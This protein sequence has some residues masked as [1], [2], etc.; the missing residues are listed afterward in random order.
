[1]TTPDPFAPQDTAAPTARVP[2]C[3]LRVELAWTHPLVWRRLT[4]PAN[5]PLPRLRQVLDACMGWRRSQGYEFTF[6]DRSYAPRD[7]GLTGPPDVADAAGVSLREAAG[8]EAAFVY[9]SDYFGSSRVHRVAVEDVHETNAGPVL[10]ACIAGSGGAPPAADEPADTPAADTFDLRAANRR[11]R[12]ALSAA[13]AARRGRVA[14]GGGV[15]AGLLNQGLT[16]LNARPIGGTATVAA[17]GLGRSGTTMLAR[18]MQALGLP[19]GDHLDPQTAEDRQLL[20]AI[21]DK[22]FTAFRA[23]CRQR[24]EAA[25]VWGFK[26]PALRHFMVECE[27][28]MRDPRFIVVFR[29]VL[30]IGLRNRIA[31]ASEV[32]EGLRGAVNGYTRLLPQLEKVQAPVLLISY[33]K[34]LMHPHRTASAIAEFCGLN[35]DPTTIDMVAAAVIMDSDPQYLS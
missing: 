17:T 12:E 3:L 28:A 21:K 10:E 27:G 20:T 33:E 30:A 7:E 29:D 4:V 23:L 19:M 34:A 18:V 11:I 1:M 26:C 25:P 31:I 8:G 22:D 32:V 35:P 5:I 15:A 9:V 13:T 6:A 16:V 14:A 2:R 24:D